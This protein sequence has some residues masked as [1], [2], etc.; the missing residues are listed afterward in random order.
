[1]RPTAKKIQEAHEALDVILDKSMP[2][3]P[4]CDGWAYRDMY[5]WVTAE[6]WEEMLDIFGEGNYYLI[7]SSQRV[8]NGETW[9]RGQFFLSQTALDNISAHLRAKAH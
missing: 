3:P 2:R 6:Y 5:S 4:G 1:M 9:K 8:K 7:I